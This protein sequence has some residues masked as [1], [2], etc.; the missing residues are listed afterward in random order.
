[1]N[2][3]ASVRQRLY[4]LAKAQNDDFQRILTQYALERLL[5]R[6]GCSPHAGRFIL[7]GA[8]L[9][10]LWTEEPHRRTRDL[11]LLG[12]GDPSPERLAALFREICV[13]EVE[14]DGLVFDA[15]TVTAKPI[16]EENIYGGVRVTLKATLDK[17]RIPVQVDVGFGDSV[18]PEPVAIEFPTLLPFPSPQLR[19][20]VRETVIA[21]KFS[22]MVTL[23][24]DNSRM[25][26]FFDLW[27]LAKQFAFDGER[28]K[29][30]IR[31][32]FERRTLS[33]PQGTPTA[34]TTVF[35]ENAAKQTQ[36]KAFVAHNV[37]EPFHSLSLR[38]V[39]AFLA[40]FLL[41]VLKALQGDSAFPF[42][43]EPAGPWT[44]VR[45][46]SL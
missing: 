34:L 31:A 1:M 2:I 6:L 38:E 26:D 40:D 33:I 3:A 39:I 5:Y 12:A 13:L 14:D 32:T 35:S 29:E 20:Y 11:D 18:T 46:K 8:L 16:R 43:W 9:F 45:S 10:L 44:V 15:A 19:A 41:P 30:A 21:E 37:S 24:L 25:K 27:F 17:A 7:K 4:N 22:A 28:L 23:D 42:Q 36:W